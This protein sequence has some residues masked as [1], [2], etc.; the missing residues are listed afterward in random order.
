MPALVELFSEEGELLGNKTSLE[1]HIYEIIGNPVK[2]L[3]GGSLSYFTL[4]SDYYSQKDV[5]PRAQK[6]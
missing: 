5:R 6:I 2:A 1:G 3:R 4:L